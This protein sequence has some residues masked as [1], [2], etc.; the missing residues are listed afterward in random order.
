M[1]EQSTQ[2]KRV[3]PTSRTEEVGLWDT[4][5][6]IIVLDTDIGETFKKLHIGVGG[7]VFVEGAY[8]DPTT[9]LKNVIPYLGLSSD[10]WLT[11]FGRRVLS[12]SPLG[13]TTASD[14]T[15]YSGE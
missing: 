4:H 14:I 11:V 10:S 7:D 3:N 8:I 6:G 15:W 1:T 5:G 2:L 9:G 12:A 13:N